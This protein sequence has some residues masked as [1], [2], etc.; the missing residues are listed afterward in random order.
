MKKIW[1]F[2]VS[3]LF[4]LFSCS[5]NEQKLVIVET[6]NTIRNEI[7]KKEETINWTN[8]IEG[9]LL[10]K[11]IKQNEL[12]LSTDFIQPEA[13]ESIKDYVP[14][15]IPELKG[16]TS[17]DTSSIPND[18]LSLVKN[19]CAQIKYNPESNLSSF[20]DSDYIF[21]YV[22]FV[23]DLKQG[24]KATFNAK[25][26]SSGVFSDYK[27]GKAEESFDLMQIPVRFYCK[28]GYLDLIFDI[29]QNKKD[30]KI[31]QIEIVRWEAEYGK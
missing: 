19:A 27:I 2:G 3:L 8:D 20:F 24:Y 13:Y 21:N 18:Y 4:S 7:Q 1:I 10:L 31:Q 22:F 6:E 16:F 15:V 11:D 17:L 5:N 29:S 12:F 23:H 25:Y 30:I 26:P 28:Y 9:E 14:P